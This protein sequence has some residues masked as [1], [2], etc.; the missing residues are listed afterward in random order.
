M[1]DSTETGRVWPGWTPGNRSWT[2]LADSAPPMPPATLTGMPGPWRQQGRPMQGIYTRPAADPV[3]GQIDGMAVLNG[4]HCQS[5]R[6]PEAMTEW[7]H[8]LV[9]YWQPVMAQGNAQVGW[10][11]YMNPDA[12]VVNAVATGR[13]PAGYAETNLDGYRRVLNRLAWSDQ[14]VATTYNDGVLYLGSTLTLADLYGPDHLARLMGMYHQ[15]LDDDVWHRQVL[16]I[17][18]YLDARLID[19]I[20]T[21]L[22]GLP[23]PV[24]A[25]VLGYPPLVTAGWLLRPLGPWAERGSLPKRGW[26]AP[27]D[28]SMVGAR[29]A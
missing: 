9:S 4:W 7:T 5:W 25:L 17:S 26:R 18:N 16:P 3:P 12:Y 22:D 21:R 20:A 1:S 19:L 27:A 11:A 2:L 28:T 8:P 15:V 13:K 24:R 29:R 10:R 14:R 23:L 6:G